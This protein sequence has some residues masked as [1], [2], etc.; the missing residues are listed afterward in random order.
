MLSIGSSGQS[1]RNLQ[2]TLNLIVPSQ[3]LLVVDGL[4]GPKTNARVVTFQK[5]AGLVADGI[6]GPKTGK[7][8][9]RSVLTRVGGR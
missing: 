3:P 9:V 4:F 5:Q 8:L 7:A 1:V 6:V 2:E